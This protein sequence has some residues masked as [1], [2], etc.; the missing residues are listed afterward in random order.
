MNFLALLGWSPGDDREIMSLGEMV[1]SFTLDRVS[2][3]PAVF[4]EKKLVWMN[5]QYLSTMADEDLYDLVG[6][7]LIQ[8]GW[9]TDALLQE[10]R[11]YVLGC[12]GL[13]RERMKRVGDF[14]EQ[15]KY[16]FED[17]EQYEEKAVQKH[18]SREGLEDWFMT[19]ISRFESLKNWRADGL[20]SVV[21][22]FAEEMEVGAGEVIHP[23]RVALTGSGASPG[24]F[25]LMEVLGKGR[26]IRR[27]HKAIDYLR[28]K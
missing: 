13:M 27:L 14:I 1:D 6:D 9:V 19:L 18:W 4:D 26:V 5:G 7:V 3:N 21:R 17:P 15:G 2:K 8:A 20:E 10:N 16:F 12:I 24:L 25:E 11:K 22:G 23:I 28:K